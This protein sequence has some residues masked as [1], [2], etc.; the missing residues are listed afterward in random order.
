M[1]Q[2]EG[3]SENVADSV[4]TLE[5]LHAVGVSIHVACCMG[6]GVFANAAVVSILKMVRIRLQN[7]IQVM[8]IYLLLLFC[9]VISLY[10]FLSCVYI[11]I[12]IYVHTYN[13][14]STGL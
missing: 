12:C 5:V 14:R 8:N 10:F 13:V 1:W 6:T 4:E 2:S 3:L 9:I 7:A 11:Y